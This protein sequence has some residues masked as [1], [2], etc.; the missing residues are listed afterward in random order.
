L[1]MGEA[2]IVCPRWEIFM[3]ASSEESP[4]MNQ[5]KLWPNAPALSNL[6]RMF[7]SCL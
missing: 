6:R 5:G 1:R 2:W 7:I 4:A 3:S